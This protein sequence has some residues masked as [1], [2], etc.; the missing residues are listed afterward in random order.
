MKKIGILSIAFLLYG[1]TLFAND[2]YNYTLDL[3]QV[4]DDKVY[5]E[6]VT[7]NIKDKEITFYLPKMIPGTYAI[8]DYGRMVSAFKALDKKGRELEVEHPDDNSWVI[9]KAN[10]LTKITYWIE[11]TYDTELE[12]PE[13]FQPAGT[14]IEEGKNFIIN[15]GGYF[16]YFEGKKDEPFELK[17]IKPV[18]FYGATGLVPAK[19]D[20]KQDEFKVAGYDELVDSP[21]MYSQA[22]TAFV[23]V[24]NTDV[25]VAS[26]SPNKK[27]TANEIAASIEEVLMA[28]QK[29]LG[30]TLPVDKYAFIFYFTDQ[31]VMSY[32]ALEHSYSSFYYMPEMT[33]TQMA[34]QLRDFAAHEF[35][36]I[37]TPLTIHS[38]EIADFDFNDP[39]M[40]KHLW[41]YEG[42]TE[43]FAGNMQ[44]KY[45]LI[46]P[47][48]YLQVLREKMITATQF[49][50]TVAFTTISK[51]T[52]D[53][54]EDQYYN[55][56]QKG[57]LI[58]MAL[59]IQLRELS[60]GKYG[61]QNLLA[62]LSKRYGKD[63]AFDDDEL[64]G[65]ITELTYPEIGEF[66]STYVGGPKPLPLED[67]FNKVGVT[68]TPEKIVESLSLGLQ[69]NNIA[70][71]PYNGSQYLAIQNAEYLNPQGDS[72]GFE[73]GDIVIA[74]N[75][76]DT[77]PLGPELGNFIGQVQ[78]SLEVDGTL[79]YTIMR[80]NTDGELE[81]KVLG[82]K[83]FPIQQ[84]QIYVLEFDEDPTQE[85]LQ[86]QKYWLEP[87]Q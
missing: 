86:L 5:I 63:K 45:G 59:D 67:L 76:L 12:G 1:F 87:Q 66:L 3:T 7:P 21:I 75:G 81:K 82:A 10:K 27:V 69:Q 8:E 58:G 25:L 32:G 36:H 22:D 11:D 60:K 46:T 56:Y 35:F 57:A 48:E 53:Q 73:N 17:I 78:E 61:V 47:E 14:N 72:L 40:S 4:K 33:I 9:K 37:V 62:D 55:V 74:I 50:D 64:F 49:I 34:Q 85:Q 30:G 19:I 2:G 20:K 77:P 6:L 23:K 18:G 28:Q 26:Y 16:G 83:V 13:I 42:V 31:P 51:G 71:A 39:E 24:G 65:V 29:Y 44:V 70:V 80:E 43:Y 79:S 41:M 68:F 38:D 84:A 54:Y 52:L 15:S